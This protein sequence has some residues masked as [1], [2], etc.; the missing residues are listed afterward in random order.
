M[1]T[2]T[3]L[4]AG[5]LERRAAEPSQTPAFIFVRGGGEADM[6]LSLEGLHRRAQTIAAQ[7]RERLPA[8]ARVLL[9]LPPGFDYLE[10]VFGCFYANVIAVSAPP[11]DPKRLHRTLPR[12]LGIATDAQLDGVLTTPEIAA[13]AAPLLAEGPLADAAWIVV[14]ADAPE[15]ADWSIPPA[16][17]HEMAFLQYTSGSTAQPRGVMLSHTNL[18]TNLELLGQ[19][20]DAKGNVERGGKMLIWLPPYHDMGLM[21]LLGPVLYGYQVILMSPI[22]VIKRPERWLQ[23][24]SRL[25]ASCSGG[26]NFSYDLCVRRVGPEVREQLD[27]SC[28]DMAFNGAEPIRASTIEAFSEV[29][30]PCGFSRSAFLPGYGLAEATLMVAAKKAHDEPRVASFDKRALAA[31]CLAPPRAC[32]AEHDA[33]RMRRGVVRSRDRDRRSDH[34]DALRAR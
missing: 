26:P 25:R 21:A 33:R 7:L 29:F 18:L 17:P 27:L 32:E 4:L 23:E 19:W 11:P 6:P 31:G 22:D 14:P 28:W 16:D 8:R 34:A 9:L 20:L 24:V 5:A 30:A 13:A 3:T 15:A 12:L 2:T 10:A 1:T